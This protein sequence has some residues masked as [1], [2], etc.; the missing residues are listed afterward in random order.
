MQQTQTTS[1]ATQ[2][3][4]ASTAYLQGVTDAADGKPERNPYRDARKQDDYRRGYRD[5]QRLAG[6][7]A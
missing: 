2:S 3:Q 1:A 6:G 5:G 4:P 7:G